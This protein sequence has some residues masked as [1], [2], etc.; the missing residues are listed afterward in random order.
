MI[1]TL[2]N[3]QQQTLYSWRELSDSEPGEGDDEKEGHATT[4]KDRGIP[5]GPRVHQGRGILTEFLDNINMT[6]VTQKMIIEGQKCNTQK[7]YM[8]TIGVFDDWM[9]E[10]NYTIV[11]I[12]NKKI[13]FTII[14]FVTQLT[15]TKKT[16]LSSVIH[17]AP[18]LN[19]MLSLIFGTVQVS[20]TAQRLTTYAISNLQIN[21]PR[22]GST[23]DIN[24]LYEYWRE[25]PESNLLSNEE[26]QV[27]LASPLISLC[28][29]I[30]EEIANIDL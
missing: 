19:T 2:T 28:F 23:W 30:L 24:Q 10:K 14:E 26:L 13:P 3:M 18:I 16:K 1:Q 7:R 17:H 6:R 9:K 27:K 12:I 20:A 22:Y 15:R 25:R 11:D 5:H 29:V 4:R 21:N 8:Q